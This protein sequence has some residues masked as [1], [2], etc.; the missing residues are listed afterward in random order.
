[1]TQALEQRL[2]SEIVPS[3][4]QDRMYGTIDQY[5]AGT[6]ALYSFDPPKPL[7]DL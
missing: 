5:A 7:G 4:G 2:G 6:T 1:M 3:V